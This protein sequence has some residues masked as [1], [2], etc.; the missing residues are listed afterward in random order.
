MVAKRNKKTGA[1]RG[2]AGQDDRRAEP[3]G[4]LADHPGVEDTDGGAAFPRQDSSGAGGSPHEPATRASTAS[5]QVREMV[6]WGDGT[7]GGGLRT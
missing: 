4:Q 7:E 5:H 2:G 1:C 6:S 3:G